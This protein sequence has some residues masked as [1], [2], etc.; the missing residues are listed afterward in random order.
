[1]LPG[2]FKKDSRI[3]L[4]KNASAFQKKAFSKCECDGQGMLMGDPY[5]SMAQ[6]QFNCSEPLLKDASG[7]IYKKD[8]RTWLHKS[9]RKKMKSPRLA[10]TMED[11]EAHG[12]SA[13]EAQEA[14]VVRTRSSAELL[15]VQAG[16]NK[17]KKK[18]TMTLM[19]MIVTPP[20]SG[21]A[22]DPAPNTRQRCKYR[23]SPLRASYHDVSGACRGCTAI[24][25]FAS[26]LCIAAKFDECEALPVQDRSP[27]RLALQ[28]H[29]ADSDCD[30]NDI[31]N[32][33]DDEEDDDD[34]DDGDDVFDEG[35]ED[36]DTRKLRDRG[37]YCA[38]AGV[39]RVNRNHS[40]VEVTKDGLRELEKMMKEVHSRVRS[41]VLENY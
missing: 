13:G 8:S 21:G 6:D 12:L 23:C 11:I 3:W 27:S 32:C 35:M 22:A 30:D 26:D 29:F 10:T 31:D 40:T 24:S 18:K 20:S 9:S 28:D 15:R 2:G 16:A 7:R 39:Q 4:H 14:V 25:A 17:V 36:A 33:D 38:G 1:M 41:F 19:S 34:G 5:E 37:G